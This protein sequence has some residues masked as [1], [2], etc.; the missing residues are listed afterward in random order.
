MR[1]NRCKD[2]RGIYSCQSPMLKQKHRFSSLLILQSGANQPR[3][4]PYYFCWH[5]KKMTTQYCFQ[6]LFWLK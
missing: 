6:L 1:G 5:I 4:L 2:V 3:G